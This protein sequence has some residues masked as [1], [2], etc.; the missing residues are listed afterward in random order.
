MSKKSFKS[1]VKL[2]KVFA[3]PSRKSKE[4]VVLSYN[5]YKLK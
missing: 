1:A 3:E 5:L 4:G 2:V